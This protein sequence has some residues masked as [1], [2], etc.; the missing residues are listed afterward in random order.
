[1]ILPQLIDKRN[2]I[3][4]KEIAFISKNSIFVDSINSNQFTNGIQKLGES[5]C[6]PKLLAL[7]GC[8]NQSIYYRKFQLAW[9]SF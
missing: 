4:I 6:M 3:L 7:K 5:G 9:G 1:M 2:N 8:S